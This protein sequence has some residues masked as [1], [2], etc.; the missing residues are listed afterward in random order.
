MLKVFGLL[1]MLLMFYPLNVFS[2]TIQFPAC[3]GDLNN[4]GT[5][6]QEE[7]FTCQ[8]TLQGYLC[9]IGQTECLGVCPQGGNYNPVTRKCE[10]PLTTEQSECSPQCPQGTTFDPTIKKCTVAPQK[11]C[12]DLSLLPTGTR[13]SIGV[14]KRYTSNQNPQQVFCGSDSNCFVNSEE[15]EYEYDEYGDLSSITCPV[16]RCNSI[17]VSVQSC[18]DGCKQIYYNGGWAGHFS[19]VSIKFSLTQE[20][21]DIINRAIYYSKDVDDD[22]GLIERINNHYYVNRESCSNCNYVTIHED[23]KNY[24]RVGENEIY[25]FQWYRCGF[26]GS[27][28]CTGSCPDEDQCHPW[29]YYIKFYYTPE[30]SYT[31]PQGTVYSNGVCV[32]DPIWTCPYGGQSCFPFNNT[33]I[34]TKQFC[35]IGTYNGSVCVSDPISWTCPLT[36]Q[37]GQVPQ[38]HQVDDRW[39]CSSYVCINEDQ[40]SPN[41]PPPQGYTD[42]GARDEE[43]NCVGQVYI[44]SGVSTRCRHSGTQTGF[45][46][47]CNQEVGEPV[48]DNPNSSDLLTAIEIISNPLSIVTE[49]CDQQDVS[50]SI[51]NRSDRC[52]YI[53]TKCIEKWKFIGCV[54]RADIYCCFNSKLGAIIHKQG[55]PQ[56]R[57]GWGTAD[58][59]NCRGFTPEEF[60]SLDFE[61]IDFS[62]YIED[63]ERNIRQNL[64]QNIDQEL[65]EDIQNLSQ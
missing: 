14:E 57:I 32:T 49:K 36:G 27:F 63:I 3:G 4:D 59:P 20:Q 34:C 1:I 38:C 8:T 54:Q 22:Y 2:N 10:I 61:K 42:D 51:L 64:E 45:H 60:Q 44:F 15:C 48:Y 12:L 47:C 35:P 55:R 17:L 19:E 24:L 56:L 31:C 37:D 11:N 58:N 29:E 16:K 62:S 41:D 25:H 39:V 18:G 53:G 40:T 50:T 23:A 52:Q 6:T 5:I 21:L 28:I 9:P 30:C 33:M 43:G 13:C 46:N 7:L 65:R 26:W